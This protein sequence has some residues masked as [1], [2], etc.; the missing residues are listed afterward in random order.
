MT[1]PTVIL[2]FSQFLF[3]VG[4]TRK[5]L[6]YMIALRRHAFFWGFLFLWESGQVIRGGCLVFC[7]YYDL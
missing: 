3:L 1:L 5:R 4:D 6:Y 2:S 7:V